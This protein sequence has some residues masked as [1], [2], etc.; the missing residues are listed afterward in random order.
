MQ[1]NKIRILVASLALSCAHIALAADPPAEGRDRTYAKV[2]SFCHD[3]GVGPA[4]LG[5]ALPAA[6]I[7]NVVRHGFRAMPSFRSSEIDNAALASVARWVSQSPASKASTASPA[8]PAP[9]AAP[10]TKAQ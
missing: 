10:A 1:S 6:Y 5:R 3:K 9:S 8:S 2:C 7:E 4:I